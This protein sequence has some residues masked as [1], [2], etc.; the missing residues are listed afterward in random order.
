MGALVGVIG[1]FMRHFLHETPIFSDAKQFGHLVKRPILDTIKKHKKA[2]VQGIA[3]YLLD[4]LGYN[5]VLIYSNFFFLEVH[6]F[7]LSEVYKIN[8]FTLFTSLIF[9]PI[10][11][12]FGN[13]IGNVRLAKWAAILIFIFACP[14]YFLISQNYLPLIYL[15]QGVVNVLIVSY[16]CNMPM[17]LYR[18]FPTEVRYTC[19][20]LVINLTVAVFGGTS[21]LIVHII[22]THYGLKIMPGFYLMI[23]AIVGFFTLRKMKDLVPQKR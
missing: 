14:M 18:I 2:L 17:I 20:A 13:Y 19:T 6:K 16:A 4:I 23:G 5:L 15:G 12:R 10:M 3:V 1:I 22:I 11:G 21:P 9:F 7:S 8:I